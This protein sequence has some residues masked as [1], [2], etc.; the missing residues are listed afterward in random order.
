MGIAAPYWRIA[1]NDPGGLRDV[2]E[3]F[4][5]DKSVRRVGTPAEAISS[6]SQPARPEGRAFDNTADH[7]LLYQAPRMWIGFR[8]ASGPVEVCFSSF[9]TKQP[10][11]AYD[12]EYSFDGVS[13]TAV[14]PTITAHPYYDLYPAQPIADQ[15][16]YVPR[17]WWRFA[18]TKMG[19]GYF[20]AN[21]AKLYLRPVL[22]G[23]DLAPLGTAFA[24]S[25][26]N[27]TYLPANILDTNPD[28]FWAN[29]SGVYVPA[30]HVG[31]TL[32]EAAWIEQ[33]GWQVRR[34]G[35]T[36]REGPTDLVVQS[37][38]DGITWFTQYQKLGLPQ[39]SDGE[40]RLFP[41]TPTPRRRFAPFD[42]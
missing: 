19:Y 3:A 32:P 24:S 16:D 14:C 28:T 42:H 22:G 2:E 38:D 15:L 37:S 40:T 18:I 39:W 17:R 33:F 9:I 34:D 1:F 7:C 13:W 5:F 27:T 29:N 23:K 25:S 6:G 12:L 31:V 35:W 41:P 26:V 11:L 30:P 21:C 4:F 20:V 36:F 10:T 8:S